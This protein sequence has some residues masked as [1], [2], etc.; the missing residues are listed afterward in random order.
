MCWRAGS[1]SWHSTWGSVLEMGAVMLL[2][3]TT[4]SP[5]FLL[6]DVLHIFRRWDGGVIEQRGADKPERWSGKSSPAPRYCQGISDLT[7]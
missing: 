2:V 3:L 6:M 7:P 1:G 4:S 5:F